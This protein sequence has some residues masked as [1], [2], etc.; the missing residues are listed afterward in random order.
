M[1]LLFFQNTDEIG[2]K[3]SS[4]SLRPNEGGYVD[5]VIV[6]RNGEG[7][8]FS[9]V[10]IRTPRF[11]RVGDKHSSRHGQKG[12]LGMIYDQ[13]EMPFTKSG[14]VP[15]ML[16]NPHAIPSRMTIAQ[17]VECLKGKK[18]AITGTMEDATPFTELNIDKL[19]ETMEKNGFHK[20][21]NEV[22]YNGKTGAQ[23]NVS[24]FIGPTFYQR[25][26]HMVD[27]KIH[28]RS[29]GP[30]VTLTRQPLE[31]RSRD[32]GLRFGEMERDCILSHG[33]ASFLKETLLDR[34]DNFKKFI[35][36]EC[37]MTAVVNDKKNI[38]SCK[39]CDNNA[40]FAEIRIPY[41]GK[42][43][44]QELQAMSIASRIVTEM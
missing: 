18:G 7:Y 24:I 30:Y 44:F 15:D 5:K 29:T 8:K 12:T 43:F 1:F 39:N 38:Y 34:S 4:T 41:A 28:S 17:L 42:L 35:C 20:H 16:V 14:L 19:S 37:G 31:G 26:R 9:K 33:S 25:L 6:A 36:K 23:L 10:R 2:Y 11:P 27:D 13:S 40:N 21:G 32:G 3:D 22:L